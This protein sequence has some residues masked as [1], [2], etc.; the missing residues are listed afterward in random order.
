MKQL[1]SLEQIELLGSQFGDF[2]A[3]AMKGTCR[4]HATEVIINVV[5]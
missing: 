5:S 1:N 3:A 2:N 4:N